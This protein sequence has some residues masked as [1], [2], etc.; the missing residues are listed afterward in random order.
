[1]SPGEPAAADSFFLIL[2]VTVIL[3]SGGGKR[4]S[5]VRVHDGDLEVRPEY[6][7][8]GPRNDQDRV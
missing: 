3:Y 1:M 2:T 7:R 6:A 8:N 4:S 5:P